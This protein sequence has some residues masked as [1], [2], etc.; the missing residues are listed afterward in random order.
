MPELPHVP[1]TVLL[2]LVAGG[3]ELA[4]SAVRDGAT[5]SLPELFDEILFLHLS[6]LVGPDYAAAAA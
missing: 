2:A 4:M 1:D 6:V 3:D 5:E